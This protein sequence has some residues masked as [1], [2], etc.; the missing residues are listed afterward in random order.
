MSNKEPGA[1]P[2]ADDNPPPHQ[3]AAESLPG[4][5]GVHRSGEDTEEKCYVR[6]INATASPV[7]VIWL[8]YHGAKVKYGNL[9]SKAAQTF[10]TF[11]GHPWIFQDCETKER[12]AIQKSGSKSDYFEVISFLRGSDSFSDL[13]KRDLAAGKTVIC[14]F[15]VQ[16]VDKLRHLALK[17]VRKCL[18]K[19]EDCFV[20]EVP[21]SMQFE[22][23][24]IYM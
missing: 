10:Y 19:K 18:V 17:T 6:F 24:E 2:D 23:A 8:D 4:I 9:S 7:E 5:E 21:Q 14:V 13:E 22:L 16:P 1:E 15:I 12:L 3:A 20:L 11:H